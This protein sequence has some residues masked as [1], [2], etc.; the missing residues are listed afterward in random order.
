MVFCFFTDSRGMFTES[1]LT[2]AGG[3]SILN[4]NEIKIRRLFAEILGNNTA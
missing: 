3:G 1:S 2:L 4:S